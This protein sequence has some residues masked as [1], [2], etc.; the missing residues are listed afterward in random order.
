MKIKL[1]NQRVSSYIERLDP[2]LGGGFLRGASMLTTCSSGTPARNPIS[3][4]S[5]KQ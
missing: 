1:S 2:M 5:N 3:N 4:V